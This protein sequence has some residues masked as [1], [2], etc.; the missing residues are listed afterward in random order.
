MRVVL[1]AAVCVAAAAACSSGGDGPEAAAKQGEA[2]ASRPA[3]PAVHPF[4]EPVTVKG[5]KGTDLRL[6]PVGVLYDKGNS[7]TKP[8]N[9]WFIAIAV[10]AEALTA[11]DTTGAPIDGQGFKWRGAGETIDEQFNGDEPVWVGSVNGFTVDTPLDPGSPEVGIE[12]MDV[13]SKAGARLLYT[14]SAGTVTEW[15]IPAADTGTG[16]TKVRAVIK[17]FA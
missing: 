8:E 16:L 5:M 2:G 17:K 7:T 10:R 13:P 14:D 12:S 11:P 1:S 9:G 15:T 3:V 6:T 4:G